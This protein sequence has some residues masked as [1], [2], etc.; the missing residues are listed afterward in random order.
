MWTWADHD[1]KTAGLV[2][3]DVAGHEGG[4]SRGEFCFILAVAA[5]ATGWTEDQTVRNKA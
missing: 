4:N 1:E 5:I 3:I 2:P